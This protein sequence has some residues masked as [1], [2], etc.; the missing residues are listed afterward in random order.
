[1]AVVLGVKSVGVGGGG[2][3]NGGSSLDGSGACN[4]PGRGGAAKRSSSH[5]PGMTEH[6]IQMSV[7]EELWESTD[8]IFQ[9]RL[10]WLLIL[11]PIAIVGD[12]LELLSE[13]TCFAFSGIAL[14][15]CAERYVLL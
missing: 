10:T 5:P 12:S 8:Y 13:A 6:G 1:M 3:M 2:V 14:I 15:P 11:G 9:S 4:H 7:A